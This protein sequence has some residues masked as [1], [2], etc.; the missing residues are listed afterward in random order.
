MTTTERKKMTDSDYTE[1]ARRDSTWREIV[2][3][4]AIEGMTFGERDLNIGGKMISGDIDLSE[5]VRIIRE[6]AGIAMHED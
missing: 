2:A 6:N 5:A 4:F 3:S 1:L